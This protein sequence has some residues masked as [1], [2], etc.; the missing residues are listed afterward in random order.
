MEDITIPRQEG[1]LR[2]FS[3]RHEFPNDWYRFFNPE[4]VNAEIQTLKLNLTKERF[5]FLLLGKDF[6]IESME[7]ILNF[8]EY[9]YV[10]DYKNGQALPISIADSSPLPFTSNPKFGNMPYLLLNFQEQ[11]PTSIEL[12]VAEDDVENI[13]KSLRQTVES[14]ERLKKDAID[15]LFIILRYSAT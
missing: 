1:L 5:P 6:A 3:A 7:L 8:K 14:H 4:D 11:I 9:E 13:P 12:T 2:M 15:D 10:K